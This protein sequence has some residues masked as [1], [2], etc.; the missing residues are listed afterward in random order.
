MGR[1]TTREKLNLKSNSEK[2]VVNKNNT[3][4]KVS[5][6]MG[7]VDTL[8]SMVNEIQKSIQT[9]NSNLVNVSMNNMTIA[10]IVDTKTE[11]FMPVDTNINL[12]SVILS[13][14]NRK[15]MNEFVAEQKNKQKLAR[16]GLNP[17]NRILM[18]GAS[19]CGKTFSAKALA[20]KLNCV[21]C[22]VD[23]AQSLANNNIAENIHG[24]FDYANDLVKEGKKPLVFLDEC[25]SV[26][27]SRDARNAESGTV[28]RATNTLFQC[29]DQS[30]NEMIIIAATNMLH[31]LDAAFERRFQV[32]MEFVAPTT[33]YSTI[34]SRFLPKGITLNIDESNPAWERQYKISYYE[35][36][37][38]TLK[39]S[40]DAILKDRSSISMHDIYEAIKIHVNLKTVIKSEPMQ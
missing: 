8:Q 14:I 15:K 17:V 27:W 6:Y 39:V 1:P 32:K 13:D 36:Q 40:K 11:Y 30:S 23:I 4:Y 22:Y 35:I 34:V 5:E 18:Y 9:I 21:M 7:K 26:A 3:D 31:R 25:D 33:D 28:R 10:P 16:Y 12:D 24:I 2:K 29:M 19:G 38:I 37:E 20:N